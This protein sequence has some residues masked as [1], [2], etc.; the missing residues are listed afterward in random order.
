MVESL[1]EKLSKNAK[2]LTNNKK[3]LSVLDETIKAMSSQKKNLD[4]FELT[5]P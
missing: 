2:P 3:H 1:R 4:V 5:Q